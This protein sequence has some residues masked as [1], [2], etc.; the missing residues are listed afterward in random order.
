MAEEKK[1]VPFRENWLASHPP[2][3]YHQRYH[4]GN[5]QERVC[6]SQSVFR[7]YSLPVVHHKIRSTPSFISYACA[8]DFSKRDGKSKRLCY[9]A[10]LMADFMFSA[11]TLNFDG[12]RSSW[13]RMLVYTEL[14]IQNHR[15]FF[16]FL[17]TLVW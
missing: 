13:V 8:V 16:P 6:D 15:T 5:P 9:H 12:R 1:P 4:H 10:I 7:R 14:A 17:R 2:H 11:S 3:Q